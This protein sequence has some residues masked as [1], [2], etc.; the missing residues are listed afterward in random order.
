MNIQQDYTI[1]KIYMDQDEVSFGGKYGA[2][3]AVIAD[4]SKQLNIPCDNIS[5]SRGWD[6]DL[7]YATVTVVGEI[8]A[9][10][11]MK[12]TTP[13]NNHICKG[14][15]NNRLNKNLDKICWH[16]GVPVT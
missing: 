15:K 9:S 8:G 13:I 14:C 6:K 7:G 16:C 3:D 12:T 10:L 2:R 5:W 4:I 11:I 1:Y